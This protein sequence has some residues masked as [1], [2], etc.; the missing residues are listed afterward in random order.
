MLPPA[1]RAGPS[2]RLP[3]ASPAQSCTGTRVLPPTYGLDG[4]RR[5]LIE[6]GTMPEYLDSGHLVFKRADALMAVPFD[7]RTLQVTG[8][9]LPATPRVAFGPRISHGEGRG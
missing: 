6:G 7:L 4:I 5:V 2:T 1:A 8:T 3:G 9:A